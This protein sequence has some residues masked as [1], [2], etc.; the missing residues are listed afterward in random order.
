MRLRAWNMLLPLIGCA[1]F[2]ALMLDPGRDPTPRV[3]AQDSCPPGQTP[4][5]IASLSDVLLTNG[6]PPM[7]RMALSRITLAPGESLAVTPAGFT[8]YYVES[9]TLK[10]AFQPGFDI[11]WAPKCT[12]P[13]GRFSGG[14][15][16]LQI[17]AE[18]LASVSQGEA[19]VSED[20]PTGPLHNGG[21]SP[22]VMLQMT[23]VLPQIDPASG[24]PIVDGATAGR[25]AT[26][27]RERQ[28]N[29][30]KAGAPSLAGS[31]AMTTPAVSTA[32]WEGD[33]REHEPRI[34]KACR[35]LPKPE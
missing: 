13:N 29:A 7:A 4:L 28:K 9:G 23:L 11:S 3:A 21:G 14:G 31:E 34:P 30:C 15:G 16:S 25:L 18:G 27:E 26:R 6:A 20:V 17:D 33:G 1:L 8:A 19:L 24:L 32:G 2:G 12:S 10:F 35:E 22:L 5:E